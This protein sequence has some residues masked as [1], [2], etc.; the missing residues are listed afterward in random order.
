M[1]NLNNIKKIYKKNIETPVFALKDVSISLPQKGLVFIV[2]KSGSGK[3]TLLNII[4]GIDSPTSG[5][6]VYENEIVSNYS[7]REMDNYRNEKVG[8][9]FQEYNLLTE[10]SVGKN[11]A[12]AFELQD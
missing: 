12:L 6:V 10:Y 3:T 8:F 11:I 2:G 7:K 5:E 1:L 4:G 9:V